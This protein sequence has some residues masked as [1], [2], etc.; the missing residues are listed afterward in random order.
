[1]RFLAAP[2]PQHFSLQSKPSDAHSRSRHQR[3]LFTHRMSKSAKHFVVLLSSHISQMSL[4]KSSTVSITERPIYGTT[5]PDISSREFTV[6]IL[7]IS[8]GFPVLVLC[9][10]ILNIM[11]IHI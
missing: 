7:L 2:A 10:T 8:C 1:M 11:H 4:G 9:L 5:D 6:G 3:A